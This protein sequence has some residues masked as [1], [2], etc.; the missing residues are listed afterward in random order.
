MSTY[1]VF[2]IDFL[3][4]LQFPPITL[5]P[6]RFLVHRHAP[7]IHEPCEQISSQI[8]FHIPFLSVLAHPALFNR[9]TKALY[10]HL[11]TLKQVTVN[12]MTSG[13][14]LGLSGD[15]RGGKLLGN[16]P[17]GMLGSAVGWVYVILS[18]EKKSYTR[19]SERVEELPS[20]NPEEPLTY[21]PRYGHL[22][23]TSC[24]RLIRVR[25]WTIMQ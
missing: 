20:Q 13:L 19:R 9:V 3:T 2:S 17:Q 11:M 14:T 21:R 25:I 24:I 18:G 8:L 1:C 12:M 7:Y 4:H 15:N 10:H 23:L 16:V 5:Q 22:I 6:F